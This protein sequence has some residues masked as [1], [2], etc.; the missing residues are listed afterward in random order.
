MIRFDIYAV[1]QLECKAFVQSIPTPYWNRCKMPIW[2]QERIIK[3][4]NFA[5]RAHRGQ[6]VPGTD[7]PYINHV[8]SVAME[9]MA[10]VTHG[11]AMKNPELLVQCALLHDVIEDTSVT[12]KELETAFGQEV[13]MGVLALS[14]NVRLPSKQARMQ[15]S[16]ARIRKQPHEVWMVKLCDRITNLQPPPKHWSREKT[17]H[18]L[19]EAIQILETLGEASDYLSSRLRQK[20]E[21]YRRFA[22][23]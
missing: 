17:L 5:S 2:N 3:A 19:D 10:T 22:N 12:P 14:K 1:I 4:W 20:I 23:G 7:I 11:G 9:A 21:E 18:Y 13:A 6:F 15:D 8:G 16:L